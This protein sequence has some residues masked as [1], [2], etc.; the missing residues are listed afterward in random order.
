MRAKLGRTLQLPGEKSTQDHEPTDKE[1][2]ISAA[3]DERARKKVKRAA[4]TKISSSEDSAAELGQRVERLQLIY[5]EAQVDAQCG[6]HA[7]NNA[8]GAA[9]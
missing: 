7:L 8:I 6:R 9:I 3:A 4:D 1:A 2:S 5:R